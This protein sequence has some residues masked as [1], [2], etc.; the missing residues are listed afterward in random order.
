MSRSVQ[1]FTA[2]SIVFFTLSGL[3][4][5]EAILSSGGDGSGTGGSV[6]YSIGQVAYTNI[7]DEEGSISLGVQQPNLLIFV[8][9]HD[10]MRDVSVAMY[11]NPVHTTATLEISGSS[12]GILPG[13][14]S[15]QLYDI[16]GRLLLHQDISEGTSH[17]P[18]GQYENAMYLIKVSCQDAE[19]KTF[20]VIKTN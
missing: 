12:D 14:C 1:F 5:Q 19:V 9:T 15:Y 2:I 20:K 11:P 16:S 8:S 18:M 13:N 17:V 3:Q 4:G 10:L 7:S 6:A